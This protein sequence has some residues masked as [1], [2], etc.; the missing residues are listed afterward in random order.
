MSQLNYLTHHITIR[1]TLASPNNFVQTITLDFDPDEVIVRSVA[2]HGA[3]AASGVFEIRSSLINNRTLCLFNDSDTTFTGQPSHRLTTFSNNSQY[4][5]S[6][7]AVGG[8]VATLAAVQLMIHL[9][10]RKY[11]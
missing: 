3:G 1:T 4:S 7:I 2:S 9:E 11:I 8:T 6:V 10:F 5:F